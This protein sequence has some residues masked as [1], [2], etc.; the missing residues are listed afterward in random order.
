[1]GSWVRYIW[2]AFNARPFGMPIPPLWFGAAAFAL[3]GA[4]VDPAFYVIGAGATAVCAGLIAS[5]P[6][7]RRA[8]DAGDQPPA[9]DE[10]AVL[11]DRLDSQ[12]RTR[13]TRLEEQCVELQR[14]LQAANAGA[15]HVQGVWQLAQL[16]LRLLAA[17][18][19]AKTVVSAPDDEDG[20]PLSTQI[21]ELERRLSQPDLDEEL[22]EALEDQGQ[23]LKKRLEIRREA[24]RRL[25]VLDAE[26]DRIRE[27]VALIREQALLTS[28]P[29]GIRRS[30]DALA[31]FLNESNRWLQD[32]EQLFGELDLPTPDPF[33]PAQGGPQQWQRADKRAGEVQ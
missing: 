22:R 16:H 1:V 20:E 6:R 19:A 7:F 12:G 2:R 15:E 13:Q 21:E 28:D 31:T 26:L 10:N 33:G 4:L 29:A 25:Q 9:R 11:L 17:R 27:Q 3:L 14:I 23:V 8:V 30:V 5:N 32:Q 18:S 24:R